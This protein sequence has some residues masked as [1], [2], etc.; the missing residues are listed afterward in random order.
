MLAVMKVKDLIEKLLHCDPDATVAIAN[1]DYGFNE[2]NELNFVDGTGVNS[3]D[4]DFVMADGQ[5][6]REKTK[7]V[8]LGPKD[9]SAIVTAYDITS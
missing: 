8:C 4:A 1:F 7:I 9:P 5:L 2:V 3:G 6:P